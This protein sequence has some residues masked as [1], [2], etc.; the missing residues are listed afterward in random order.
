MAILTSFR[1]YLI[2]ML[3][4][5]S[6]III[7]VGL[8]FM[9]LLAIYMLFLEKCLFRSSVNFLTGFL[10]CWICVCVFC[11]VWYWAVS[12]LYKIKPLS[13]TLFANI[14]S[15]SISCLFNIDYDFLCYVEVCKFGN[16]PFFLIFALFLFYWE[17]YLRKHCHNLRYRMLCLF[18][19]RNF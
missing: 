6:L 15:H 17:T 1:W 19:P 11:F 2:V 5:I 12:C 7:D 14:F 16:V 3:I 10:F 8:I 13:V 4:Y 18:F 9:F